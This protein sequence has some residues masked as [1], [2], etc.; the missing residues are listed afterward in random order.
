MFESSPDDRKIVFL[1]FLIQNDD[2]FLKEWGFLSSD[3]NRF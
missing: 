3:I 2:N 1:L